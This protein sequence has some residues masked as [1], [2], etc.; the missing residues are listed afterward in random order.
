M[1]T[2]RSRL[3]CVVIPCFNEAEV[4][5]HTYAEVKRVLAGLPG[6][7]HLLYFV[8]DGSGDATL[9]MLNQLAARDEAVRVLALSR[10]FGHQL[11]I[12]C[13]LD[14]A[15]RRADALLVM[16]ADLE[17]PPAL[18]PR[19]LAELDTG[20]DVV[21]GVRETGR[22]VG[23]LRRL[24]SRAFY[25]LFNALSDVPITP[26]APDF[27]LL[28]PRA[29]EA[30]GRMGEQRRFLR[31][32][33]AWLGFPSAQVPYVPPARVH[34]S[35]KYTLARMLRLAEDALFAFSSLPAR[36]LLRGGATLVLLGLAILLVAT[37]RTL[38]SE[39]SSALT[40][41]AALMLGVSGLHVAALG[42]VA[43]YVVR[44]L[45][46]ARGRPLYLLKQAPD[47]R[48]ARLVEVGAAHANAGRR[49][50]AGR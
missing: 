6:Y 13:G 16:D 14:H 22:Q 36:L 38:A 27:F 33:V 18:I 11:A 37:L 25:R 15:D 31:A 20:H 28:S 21:L 2:P 24:G 41:L 4:L 45:E 17:N 23:L 30:L 44:A 50:A 32:M 3:L 26:G 46:E 29:R 19:M 1:E 8:D 34:G 40:W 43:G 12:T 35:S 47:E 10:N 49:G 9:T 7:R 42:V 39:G 5:E 48:E